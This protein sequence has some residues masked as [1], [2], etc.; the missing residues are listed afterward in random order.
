MNPDPETHALPDE[1]LF[2][3]LEHPESWPDDPAIQAQLADLLEVHL[4]LQSHGS[5]LHINPSA[6]ARVEEPAPR[7]WRHHSSWLLAAAAALAALVPALYAVQHTRT[8]QIQ[9]QDRARIQAV[10]ERRGQERLWAAFFQQSTD[11]LQKFD[12]Q[13]LTCDR[14]REN[15]NPERELAM[16]L[17]DASHQLAAQGAPNPEAES[18]RANLHAWLME[19]SLEDGCMEP[20][21]VEELRKL[22]ASRNLED[23]TQRL[24]LRLREEAN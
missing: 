22:A 11:L 20:Q 13:S 14:E 15:H 17:L 23:E 2:E 21:R 12:K 6:P 9:A 5:Q 1:Q 24:G 19:V 10:A 3:L 8:L 18:V 16:A 7:P 4:A